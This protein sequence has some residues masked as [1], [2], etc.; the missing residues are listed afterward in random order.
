MSATARPSP[1]G[2]RTMLPS[3]TTR[4]RMA[5]AA[6]AR[7]MK[8]QRLRGIDDQVVRHTRQAEIAG[9]LDR[10]VHVTRR[11]RKHFDDD[12]GVGHF[13]RGARK[14][15]VRNKRSHRAR[16]RFCRRFA[17]SCRRAGHDT[18]G[19]R[20]EFRPAKRCMNGQFG[21]GVP[22]CFRATSHRPRPGAA[23]NA[24][25]GSRPRPEIHRP[26]S[27]AWSAPSWVGS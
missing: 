4:V 15:L 1:G 10:K 7:M 2:S 22:G 6:A 23:R 16:T 13:D 25:A 5:V 19:R 26:S 9:K 20:Y 17:P 24:P 18:R 11:W 27:V 12:Q 14:F 21:F 8:D 3:V